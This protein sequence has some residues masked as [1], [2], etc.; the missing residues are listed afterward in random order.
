MKVILLLAMVAFAAATPAIKEQ[1]TSFKSRHGKSYNSIEEEH[2]R[3]NIFSHHLKMIEEHNAKFEA[4]LVTY[5]MRMNHLGDML[6]EEVTQLGFNKT[7]EMRRV[8]SFTFLP[9]ANVE[10]PESIDWTQTGA[11]TPVKN[12]GH[13]GSCWAFSSVS[14]ETGALEGQLFRKTGKR[15][16][17]SE[18]QLVDCSRSYKNGGCRGGLMDNSFNYLKDVEGLQS[19]SSYPYE[20]IDNRCR[21]NKDKVVPGTQVKAY[22]DIQSMDD[23]ALQAAVATVGPVSIAVSAGNNGFMFYEGGV[24]D[25]ETCGDLDHGI[26]LVGY[27]S[28]DGEDYW[29]VKNSWGP[30]WGENGYMKLTRAKKNACGISTAASYPIL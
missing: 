4:G 19:E 26:L 17:L 8:P 6:P 16:S 18:Q 10:I 1:W 24:F 3:M 23:D 12:Q 15:V 11:V 28:E 7:E 9:P 13:C 22:T 21:Y 5:S 25:G 14:L 20:G 2:L 29:L 30:R 27:G